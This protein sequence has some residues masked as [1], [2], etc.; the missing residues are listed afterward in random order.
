MRIINGR[1]MTMEG[2]LLENAWIAFE[3]GVITDI[4]TMDQIE[5]RENDFDADGGFVLPGFIEPHCHIGLSEESYGEENEDANEYTEVFGEHLRAVDGINPMDEAFAQSLDAGF[6]TLVVSPG[7]S[8]IMGGQIA[9]VKTAG[10]SVDEMVLRT[11]IALKMALGDDPAANGKRY[12]GP[13]TPMGVVAAIRCEFEGAKAYMHRKN[14]KVN[15]R[16]EALIPVLEK[17][18]PLHI[19][20]HRADDIAAALR[21]AEEFDFDWVLI[22]GSGVERVLNLIQEAKVPVL[23]GPLTS[24]SPRKEIEGNGLHL[25]GMLHGAGV[26]FAITSDSASTNSFPVMPVWYNSMIA[27]Q[28]VG[29]GLNMEE[30]LRA[31]TIYPAQ[32]CRIDDRV[33]SLKAGKDADITVFT[34]HPLQ[35]RSHVAAVFVNGIRVR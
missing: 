7:S 31:L 21:L 4:G 5:V 30:A 25:P 3:N 35:F 15:L 13:Q 24:G 20:A 16:Y 1:I 27:A 32:I 8:S 6:T 19:H 12:N 33:G 29:E 10:R 14:K 22:H 23:A 28:T 34:E 11:P 18:I 17:K 9:A 26:P 2:P